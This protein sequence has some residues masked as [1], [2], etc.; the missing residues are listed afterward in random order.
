MSLVRI[1]TKKIVKNTVLNIALV[2]IRA[3]IEKNT[4]C[5][6]I[7]IRIGQNSRKTA[8]LVGLWLE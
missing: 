5:G 2:K 8:F 3:Y 4:L 7:L 6:K 1:R